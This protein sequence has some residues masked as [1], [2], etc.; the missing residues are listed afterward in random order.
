M[1]EDAGMNEFYLE[2]EA[3][4]GFARAMDYVNVWCS[5]HQWQ[6]GVAEMALGVGIL[7]AGLQ[8][9]ACRWAST[10]C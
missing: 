1:C 7:A 3:E 6:I 4:S 5:Q 2:G 8:T 10:S 9:G